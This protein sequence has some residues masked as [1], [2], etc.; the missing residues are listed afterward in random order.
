MFPDQ[1]FCVC[2]GRAG[3]EKTARWTGLKMPDLTI[4]IM[5]QLVS[6]RSAGKRINYV[7]ALGSPQSLYISTALRKRHRPAFCAAAVCV[8]PV[9]DSHS[10]LFLYSHKDRRRYRTC[11]PFF[12]SFRHLIA[13]GAAELICPNDAMVILPFTPSGATG[14]CCPGDLSRKDADTQNESWMQSRRYTPRS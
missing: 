6:S 8:S 12:T 5:A 7:T 11:S 1:E 9:A 2:R 14:A 3:K 4:I 10:P 13:P